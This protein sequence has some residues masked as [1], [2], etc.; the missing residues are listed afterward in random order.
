MFLVI[1]SINI[2]GCSIVSIRTG[3]GREFDNEVQFR[4]FCD[5][6][7]ITYNFS[8]PRI[9][10]SNGVVERKNG[11]LQEM[12]RTMLNEQSIPQKFWCNAIDTST[13]ILN[14]IVIRPF[15]GK[16]PYE[17]YRVEES[18]KVTF[19]ESPSPT[20]LSPLVDDDVGEEEA[21]ERN[22]K[23]G[24]NNNIEDGFIEVDE[25]V[26]IK[27]SK[28][29]PLEQVIELKNVN[30][31]LGDKSWVIA[32]QEE[33]NQFVANDVWDLVPLPKNQSIIGTKWVFRNKLD[34][35]GI[36]SRNKARLVAQGYN[37]QE[38]IDYDET[39]TPT[40]R[41]ESIQILL[42][43]ACAK[44]F[45]LYQMDVK[46]DFLNGFINEEVYVAQPLGFID[47][48]K[49]NNVYKLRKALH[50]LKQAPKACFGLEDSKP[51]K[52]PM[53][54]EIMLTKDDEADSVDSTKYQ[55][56]Y[57]YSDAWSLDQ[58]ENTLEKVPPYNS[59]FPPIEDFCTRIHQRVTFKKQSKEG[60]LQ[61]LPNKIET[62]ELL[63]HLKPCELVIR[64]NA[65]VAIG[66]R[67]HV[68]GSIALMLYCLKVSRP[69]N[70]AYFVIREMDY[71]KD[72]IDKVLPY[73]M[74]LTCL[75]KNIKATMKDHMFDDSYILVP[76]KMSFLKAKQSK[77]PPP[78]K[79]RNVVKSK[80]A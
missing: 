39:Y 16:T 17:I 64:E 65:Y 52:T 31:A 21:I 7:G 72:R 29:Y 28:S 55:G 26:N 18:L 19:D 62:N 38:G 78:K 69:Y 35:N 71:F 70:L 41:L 51:T 37:Q 50:G 77:I 74:I 56:I 33:L 60:V 14:R 68:Q 43:L 61:K 73:S 6:Q 42:A 46:S 44:D 59:N 76:R 2:L 40:T 3:H 10:Q 48:E 58:L 66:N 15:L 20:K 5:A 8:T 67:D 57:L 75:F 34:E 11:T 45:K 4:A 13:Y 25:V 30:E 63:D 24:N 32:M 80:R 36:M 47:F 22:I 9:S 27:E 49:P 23:V 79:P 12:S 53:S 1:I 54:T